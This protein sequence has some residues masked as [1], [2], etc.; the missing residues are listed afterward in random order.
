MT[1]GGCWYEGFRSM[2]SSMQ[3][4]A[5]SFLGGA[6][7]PEGLVRRRWSWRCRRWRCWI[8][9]GCMGRRGFM[10]R[11]RRT[12]CGRIWGR[13]SRWGIWRRGLR[14]QRGCRIGMS[15]EPVAGA[16]AV[17]SQVGY[18]NLCQMITRYKMREPGRP[19]AR[20][21]W[22]IWRS[23]GWA[24]LP[25]GGDE[26]PLAAAL[27]RVAK[28]RACGGRAAGGTF[29]RGNVYVE[30]QRHG[31]REEECSQPGG[32]ADCARACG[33]RWW[34]PT[35]CGMRRSMSGRCWMC[36]RR[37]GIGCDLDHAGRLLQVNSQR[38][39]RVARAMRALFRGSSGGD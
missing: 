2:S 3:S 25:D 23:F 11:R 19:R 10:R 7:L 33:C 31:E 39:L 36:L 6:S 28:R 26:G 20:R 12:G 13:R 14:R 27:E 15:A 18:Q 9:M 35:G 1:S 32:D 4:S 30:L 34:R 24:D 38:H 16:A 8:A 22:R 17:C 29:G 21:G 5:F 37:F